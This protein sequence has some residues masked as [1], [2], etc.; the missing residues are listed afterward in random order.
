M[1]RKLYKANIVI[2][3]GAS[4][5]ASATCGPPGLPKGCRAAQA[6]VFYALR[7]A[8]SFMNA[9]SASTPASG[10]AL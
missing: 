3:A 2:M 8:K 9:M 4:T 10:M 5:A 1:R 7:C 6:A